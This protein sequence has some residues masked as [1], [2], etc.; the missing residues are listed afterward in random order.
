MEEK[1]PRLPPYV[2]FIMHPLQLRIC[3]KPENAESSSNADIYCCCWLKRMVR[4]SC[5]RL[6]AFGIVEFDPKNCLGTSIIKIHPRSQKH[7]RCFSIHNYH[8]YS[9]SRICRHQNLHWCVHC[10]ARN[11]SIRSSAR[12]VNCLLSSSV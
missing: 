6:K 12:A 8:P 2:A 1:R 5:R 4:T 7:R 10:L 3:K 9:W 11:C